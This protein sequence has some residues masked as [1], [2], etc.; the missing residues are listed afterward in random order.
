MK[1]QMDYLESQTKLS[2]FEIEYAQKKL[3]IL[4]AQIALEN[5][6]NNKTQLNLQRDSTGNYSYVYTADADEVEKAQQEL[7][8]AKND[9]YEVAKNQLTTGRDNIESYLDKLNER[10]KDATDEERAAAIG[11]AGTTYLKDQ[12]QQMLKAYQYLQEDFGVKNYAELGFLEND[13]ILST[14]VSGGSVNW[15]SL[16]DTLNTQVSES[17]ADYKEALSNIKTIVDT[18]EK[19]VKSIS[20]YFVGSNSSFMEDMDKRL[21]DDNSALISSLGELIQ[22]VNSAEQTVSNLNEARKKEDKDSWATEVQTATKDTAAQVA[23]NINNAV[24]VA[25]YGMSKT[26]QGS[27]GTWGTLDE[28]DTAIATRA[29]KL[30]KGKKLQKQ[31][32]TSIKK[33]DRVTVQQISEEGGWAKVNVNGGSKSFYAKLWALKKYLASY[34]TGGYTGSWSKGHGLDSKNGRLALLHQKEIVLNSDDTS[35]LLTAVKL[36]REMKDSIQNITDFS[37]YSKAAFA[38]TSEKVIEQRVEITASFPSAK[39]ADDIRSALLSIA[40]KAYQY[41]N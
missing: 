21:S 27:G 20:D 6:Q 19:D 3:S 35:N 40:D 25:G 13:E 16:M 26:S 37:D 9:A 10:Y 18:V 7:E 11:E 39:D 23:K 22:A 29:L 24:E 1:S 32:D 4:K 36:V 41:S 2:K 33:G 31:A 8:Q 14:L 17:N 34:D 28:G 38:D 5:A 15:T 30:F 12:W